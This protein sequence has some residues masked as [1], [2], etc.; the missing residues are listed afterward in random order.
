MAGSRKK[1]KKWMAEA[2]KNARGQ[3]RGQLGARP[4]Q[5]IPMG[6]VE[7]AAGSGNET[8]RKRAQL[9]L[10]ARMI[11]RKRKAKR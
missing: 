11:G 8:L 5:P 3:L 7:Q 4:G 9:A 2:F 10:T 1:A 6:K